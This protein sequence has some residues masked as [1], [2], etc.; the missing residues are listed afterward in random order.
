[1][2]LPRQI[3][4]GRSYM[5]SRRCSQRQFLM[6]P[7]PRTND[8]FLYCLGLAALRTGVRLVGFLAMS[9]HW[10]GILVDVEGRLPEFLEIAHKLFAKHQN[11]AL[12]RWENFWAPEQTSV[13][14]LVTPDDILAKLIYTLANPVADHLVERAHHWPGAS[15]LRAMTDGK[16]IRAARPRTFFRQQGKDVLPDNVEIKLVVPPAF[17]GMTQRGFAKLVGERVQK[18]EQQ[19]AAERARTGRRVLGR[20]AVLRQ[21]PTDRPATIEPRRQLSPRVACR[22]TWRRVETLARNK[23]FVAAY[24]AAR[25][26]LIAGKDALFPAGT[27]WLRRFA[28]AACDGVAPAPA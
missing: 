24:R 22:N 17:G 16:L 5:I 28:G 21:R 10:H 27:Y 8:A 11:A 3:F 12:G 2:S 1:M 20:A 23:A 18:V 19:A 6:R 26:L 9:N 13:V 14:E 25:D 4:P 7:D 15:S